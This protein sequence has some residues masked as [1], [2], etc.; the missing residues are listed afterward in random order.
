MSQTE[1][2]KNLRVHGGDGFRAIA[3]LMVL[4]HH[5][6][7]R[8]NPDQSASWIKALHYAG[9][10]AE[11]GVALFFVLSGCLLSMPFWRAY[12][13]SESMP[14]LYAYARNRVARIVPGAWLALIVS[15]YVAVKILQGEFQPFRFFSGLTFTYSFYY[16]TF[17][18]VDTNG[19]LWTIGLEVWSYIC[20]PLTIGLIF[21]FGKSTKAAFIGMSI[22]IL[23]LQ[24]LQ[25]IIIQ[26]FMTE[27]YEKGWEFGMTGGAKLWM[28]YW[29]FATFF[30]MFLLGSCAALGIC[31]VRKNGQ[32]QKIHWD[33]LSIVSLLGALYIVLR[34]EVPGTPDKFTKQPYLT[35]WFPALIAISLFGSAVGAR[36]W[37]ILDNRVL[38]YIAR[39][40]FGL[41]LWHWL[42]LIIVERKLP[43][44]YWENGANNIY[45][46]LGMITF[47]YGVTWIIASLSFR[48]FESPILRWNR[49]SLARRATQP[50]I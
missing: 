39:I 35:P 40:S 3:C 19:P 26:Y 27:D 1:L 29:N 11:V 46:W 12:L 13:A 2:N 34:F 30:T 36:F 15:T 50:L 37:K 17:F 43:N 41:Y 8:F 21:K 31:L 25:P 4:F 33:V 5:A 20:L 22:S 38:S 6:A 14:S 47:T 45:A 48:Y 28:P 24:Y 7:Q 49:R 32:D 23:F 44:G 18:P 42:L 9:W 10:R 16:K